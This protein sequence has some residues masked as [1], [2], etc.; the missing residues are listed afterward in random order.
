MYLLYVWNLPALYMLISLPKKKKQKPGWLCKVLNMLF[1]LILVNISHNICIS[2]HHIVYLKYELFV[3]YTSIK[4]EKVNNQIEK[5]SFWLLFRSNTV[6]YWFYT[7]VYL[8]HLQLH[9][10]LFPAWNPDLGP[11][12]CTINAPCSVVHHWAFGGDAPSTLQWGFNLN[13][14]LLSLATF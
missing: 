8:T 3:S 12:Y 10:L 6:R 13:P 4:L 11:C 2:K 14:F 9:L 7:A 1:N 5:Y